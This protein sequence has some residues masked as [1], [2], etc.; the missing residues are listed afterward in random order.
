[1]C[2]VLVGIFGFIS[3]CWHFGQLDLVTGFVSERKQLFIRDN[4][5]IACSML[6]CTAGFLYSEEVNFK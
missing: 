2:G 3:K 5:T 1:M 4:I 6:S